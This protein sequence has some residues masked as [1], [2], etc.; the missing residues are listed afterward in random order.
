MSFSIT[1]RQLGLV[2][3]LSVGGAAGVLAKRN[4]G[5]ENQPMAAE[6]G[7]DRNPGPPA[8]GVRVRSMP[9]TIEPYLD[10]A[11]LVPPK[12]AANLLSRL[13]PCWYPLKSGKVMHAFRL[14]GPKAV[15]PQDMY[16]HPFSDPVLNGKELAGYLLD[17]TV[18]RRHA[19]GA[20]PLLESTPHGIRIRVQRDKFA[21]TF[22]GDLGHVND[23]LAG[24]GEVGLPS[25]TVVRTP[26]REGTLADVVR[27]SVAE[28]RADQELDWTVEAFARYLDDT[29]RWVNQAGE[30]TTFSDVADRLLRRRYGEG[31]CLGTH[32]L[33]ALACLYRINQR[34]PILT[35]QTRLAIENFLKEASL[36]VAGSRTGTGA[37]GAAWAPRPDGRPITDQENERLAVTS[38]GHHLEWLAIVPQELRPD[39]KLIQRAVS[40]I[41]DVVEAMSPY[42]R[43]RFYL[44]LSHLGRALS[45]M[46]G[47]H[48]SDIVRENVG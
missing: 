1:R 42:A 19:P 20:S 18:Y 36:M 14:W 41:F 38:T 47:R 13:T 32:K 21:G 16:T 8:A 3:F 37:W 24:C 2:A 22:T 44:D 6:P 4:F 27:N 10:L 17:D 34:R 40:G 15:F 46:L 12:R 39:R 7:D 45:L 11:E 9:V 23:V 30:V 48:P 26:N 5:S 33:N 31:P 28:F 25:D 35:P 29:D 43:D